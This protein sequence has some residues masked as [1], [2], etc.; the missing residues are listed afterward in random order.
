MV[1]VLGKE[2]ASAALE[3]GMGAVSACMV[4]RK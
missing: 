4:A 2:M 3:L 1:E